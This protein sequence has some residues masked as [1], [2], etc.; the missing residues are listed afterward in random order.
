M[1]RALRLTQ[2]QVLDLKARRKSIS[3][4]DAYA[5]RRAKSLL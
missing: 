5:E 1:S 2:A 3:R 4:D